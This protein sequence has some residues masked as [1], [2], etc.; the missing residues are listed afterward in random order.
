MAREFEQ[1][2][3]RDLLFREI[4]LDLQKLASFRESLNKMVE[5]NWYP[6]AQE[7]LKT[8]FQELGKKDLEIIFEMGEEFRTDSRIPD[9]IKEVLG[10]KRFSRIRVGLYWDC[11]D[12][13]VSLKNTIFNDGLSIRM[14]LDESETTPIGF[15][16]YR[17]PPYSE[18]MDK[19]S[20]EAGILTAVIFSHFAPHFREAKKN[21]SK[22]IPQLNPSP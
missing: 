19:G 16:I 15:R 3:N 21:L 11:G 9:E 12:Y 1:I 5:D 7:Y 20:K 6:K 13:I 2:Y 18:L 10:G 4:P 17:F 22:S 8:L 14:P